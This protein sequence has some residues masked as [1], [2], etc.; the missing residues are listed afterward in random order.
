MDLRL[1]PWDP[2]SNRVQQTGVPC[3]SSHPQ[4]HGSTPHPPPLHSVYLPL[5]APPDSP[6]ECT[7]MPLPE[8]DAPG[9]QSQSHLEPGAASRR[10]WVLPGEKGRAGHQ[11]PWTGSSWGQADRDSLETE[12]TCAQ[13][14]PSISLPGPAHLQETRSG[15]RGL[16][17]SAALAVEQ[18]M[19]HPGGA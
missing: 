9:C 5:A 16:G 4:I 11:G 6:Q 2:L 19:Q 10:K 15:A 13:H 3:G 17:G 14:T 7:L 12:S 18:R 8:T 1:F